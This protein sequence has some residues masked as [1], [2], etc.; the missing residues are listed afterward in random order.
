MVLDEQAKKTLTV[1]LFIAVIIFGGFAYWHFAILKLHYKRNEGIKKGLRDD[2]KKYKKD[3][4]EIREAEAQK[5]KIEEMRRIVAEA[6]K[7]LPR[8]PDAVGFYQELIRILRITGVLTT[9]VDPQRVRGQQ[10]YT[11]IPYGITCQCRYHEFGQFLNL[12]EENQN[13]FMRVNSFNVK[14]NDNRPSIHPVN[15]SISTFMFNR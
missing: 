9:R 13:R 3:L 10:L 5:D 8:S 6:A 4:A 11:E 2:I 7:R 1:G 12:I 14:N 15:I